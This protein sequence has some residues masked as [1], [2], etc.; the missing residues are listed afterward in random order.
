MM[1]GY[2]EETGQ[3]FNSMRLLLYRWHLPVVRYLERPMRQTMITLQRFQ[4]V[5]LMRSIL[6]A[7]FDATAERLDELPGCFLYRVY[8]ACFGTSTVRIIVFLK[9]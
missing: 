7:Q 1:H 3:M 6:M 4:R 8:V 5:A 2:V 9:V